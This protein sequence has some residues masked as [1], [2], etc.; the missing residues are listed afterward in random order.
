MSFPNW[1][2]TAP[3]AID[4]PVREHRI[5][6][7]DEERKKPPG[8]PK[9]CKDLKPRKLFEGPRSR[10]KDAVRTREAKRAERIAYWA[11][12]GVVIKE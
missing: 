7:D 9:G 5:P 8:R 6:M 12:R 10:H 2:C 11:A 1:L 4:L 3:V